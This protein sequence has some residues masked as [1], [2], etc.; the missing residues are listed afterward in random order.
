VNPATWGVLEWV[1]TILVS[2]LVNMLI[3]AYFIGK[4]KERVDGTYNAR[5]ERLTSEVNQYEAKVENLER[6]VGRFGRQLA[7]FTGKANGETYRDG[8]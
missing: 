3:G 8:D 5:V 4:Y 2:G 6:E 7:A 1:G